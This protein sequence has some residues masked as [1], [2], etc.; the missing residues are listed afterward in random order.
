MRVR[1]E[2]ERFGSKLGPPV[3]SYLLQPCS[4][5]YCCNVGSAFL[6]YTHV[7]FSRNRRS[8]GRPCWLRLCLCWCRC[9]SKCSEFSFTARLAVEVE[10]RRTSANVSLLL[11]KLRELRLML[12]PNTNLS[13]RGDIA[14][15]C[16]CL[17]AWGW[18]CRCCRARCEKGVCGRLRCRCR[19][20]CRCWCW[21]AASAPTLISSVRS[22][23]CS[24]AV[25]GS[26]LADPRATGHWCRHASTLLCN[27]DQSH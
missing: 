1:F 21:W 5:P 13:R 9:S 7:R 4:E 23:S 8:R 17:P 19:C 14:P 18:Q 22:S 2:I 27:S 6:S 11:L 26:Q 12:W 24:A 3:S 10:G 20:R 16:C 25:E 15:A